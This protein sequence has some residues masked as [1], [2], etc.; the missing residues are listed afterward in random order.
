MFSLIS[1]RER[2]GLARAGAGDG[3]TGGDTLRESPDF[4]TRCAMGFS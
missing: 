4:Q 3:V 1:T 2:D